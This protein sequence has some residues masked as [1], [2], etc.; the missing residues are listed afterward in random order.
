MCL[1]TTLYFPQCFPVTHLYM[2]LGFLSLE[3][4][5]VREKFS[6]ITVNNSSFVSDS[7][8]KF[9]SCFLMF[10]VL[11]SSFDLD[12]LFSPSLISILF[13]LDSTPNS[14]SLVW[15]PTMEGSPDA[16]SE[17]FWGLMGLVRAKPFLPGLCTQ[18]LG[19]SHMVA[20]QFSCHSRVSTPSS[21]R[22]PIAAPKV[23]CLRAADTD[24]NTK[25]SIGAL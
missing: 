8:Q 14:F 23:T 22:G 5:K 7:V 6:N 12:L 9:G 20:V 13:S 19:Q 2:R 24:P 25:Q 15:I 16:F 1:I 21:L 11:F 18:P 4:D 17:E 10:C 3:W